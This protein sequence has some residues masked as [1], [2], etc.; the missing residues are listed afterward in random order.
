MQGKQ[1]ELKMETKG[2]FYNKVESLH[3][4]QG[5]AA[6]NSVPSQALGSSLGRYHNNCFHNNYRIRFICNRM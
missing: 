4:Y 6:S 1:G 2:R 5:G 3:T